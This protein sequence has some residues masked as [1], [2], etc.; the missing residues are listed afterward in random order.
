MGEARTDQVYQL[1]RL[2]LADGEPLMYE[3]TYLPMQSFLNLQ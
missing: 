3:T 2:R 1:I